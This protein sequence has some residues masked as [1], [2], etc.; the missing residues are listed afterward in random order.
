LKGSRYIALL[1][2]NLQILHS[3]T[4]DALH[5][6]IRAKLLEQ[7]LMVD[8]FII[9]EVLMVGKDVLQNADLRVK[10]IL[11]SLGA[12]FGGKHVIFVGDFFQLRPMRDRFVF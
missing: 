10:E 3:K 9:D 11:G 12:C 4:Y 2:S 7:Y 5:D 1:V 6:Q 8:L